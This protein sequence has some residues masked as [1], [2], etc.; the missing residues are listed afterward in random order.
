MRRMSK[1]AVEAFRLLGI[2]LDSDRDTI[3]HAYRQLARSVHPDVSSA[4]D[5]AERFAS[6]TEAY[7]IATT[8]PGA[9]AADH[10][11]AEVPVQRIAWLRED[12][13]IVAGPVRVDPSSVAAPGK[14]G[15]H[16]RSGR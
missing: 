14:G 4:G 5:A 1:Q 7:Q 9:Q 16:G 2:P 13:P 10:V 3:A 6:L 12:P 8:A 15:G 11:G